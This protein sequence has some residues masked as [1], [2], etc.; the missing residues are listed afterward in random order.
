MQISKKKEEGE[1]EAAVKGSSDD[2][3]AVEANETAEAKKAAEAV[4]RSKVEAQ[5]SSS[6]PRIPPIRFLMSGSMPGGGSGGGG[7][8][9]SASGGGSESIQQ[10]GPV[11]RVTTEDSDE[12]NPEL[13][14]SFGHTRSRK[15]VS[16]RQR[17]YEYRLQREEELAGGSLPTRYRATKKKLASCFFCCFKKNFYIRVNLI[18]NTSRLLYLKNNK[19]MGKCTEMRF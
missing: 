4:A 12:D 3:D 2:D 6:L 13:T 19:Y 8:V 18:G 14:V 11:I 7:G 17:E 5:L 9:G 10:A 15:R 1:E 16:L